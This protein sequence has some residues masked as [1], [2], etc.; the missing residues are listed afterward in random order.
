MY[1]ANHFILFISLSVLSHDEQDLC[2]IILKLIFLC[3]CLAEAN[4][5]LWSNY[6]SIKNKYIKKQKQYCKTF[7][8]DSKNEKK[9][10]RKKEF[11]W[12]NNPLIPPGY[13]QRNIYAILDE[14]Q[15]HYVA[16]RKNQWWS[17]AVVAAVG[18]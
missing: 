8:K 12:T 5:I 18:D 15:F 1:M 13:L 17:K 2:C 16:W 11:S 4:T 6:P 14:L 9:N 10:W 3:W 7:N